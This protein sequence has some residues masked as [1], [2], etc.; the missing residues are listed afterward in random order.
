M[1]TCVLAS[2]CGSKLLV[3]YI[4]S[5]GFNLL[6]EENLA[7]HLVEHLVLNHCAIYALSALL[8]LGTHFLVAALEHDSVDFLVTYLGDSVSVAKECSA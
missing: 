5:E 2:H 4:D 7:H 3:G 1:R 6:V 8:E